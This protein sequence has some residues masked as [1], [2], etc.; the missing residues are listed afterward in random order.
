MHCSAPFPAPRPRLTASAALLAALLTLSGCAQ[1]PA[2]SSTFFPRPASDYATAAAFDAPALAWPADRWSSAYQ[3]PQ[4]D[5]LVDEALTGSPDMQAAVARVRRAEAAGQV[6]GAALLPQVSAG[7][8]VTGDRLSSNYLTPK[9][10]TPDGWNDYGR[11][12]LDLRWELDFWGKNRAGLAA[13]TS[14]LDAS[15]AE[16]AQARLSLAAAVAA[17]YA[18][19]ARIFAV[20]D[21]VA[22][23]VEVRR[24]TLT[25]FSERFDNGLETTGSVN[26]ARARLAG[27]E[28]ELLAL[29]EQIGLQR[30]RLAALLGAGPDRGLAIG[31]PAVQLSNDFGLPAELA[32]D[33]LG[34]RPDIVAARLIAEAQAHRIEQ[35]KAEFYPN[36]N[37]AAVIG[38]Q[39]FGL[40]MLTQ[41]GSTIGSV[42]PAI[43]LP[44]FTAGRLQGELRGA[45]AGYDE[46][47]ANYNRTVARA[48]E[49]V[50]SAGLSQ[51]ALT[52][53]LNKGQ[54]AVTAAGEAHRAASD[55]Y[56]GGLANYL[57]VLFAED[58]LLGSQRNLA[59]L[60]S[61][62]FAVDVALKR[63]LGGGYRH[64]AI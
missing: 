31:R 30:N 18:E 52:A 35:K 20:R 2:L 21:T 34:R 38:V 36:V 3:D 14:Q 37:L 46:A 19:L 4:L 27:V 9:A 62:A 26:E 25:L 53:Q 44:I 51:K 54:E 12:T 22:R 50:A 5:A 61:R 45:A 1:I 33:L 56:A 15:R 58:T 64:H 7:V 6:A 48:L 10:M 24:K 59:T 13:A 16:H 49:E 17:D 32:T 57:E 63:A 39:S 43:S 29:D 8:S 47:V 42:G 55:R 11:A 40:D 41:G 23:S 60:Q 28:G